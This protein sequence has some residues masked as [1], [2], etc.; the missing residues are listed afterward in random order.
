MAR[1]IAITKKRT[2]QPNTNFLTFCAR[3]ICFTESLASIFESKKARTLWVVG[4][5]GESS[6]YWIFIIVVMVNTNIQSVQYTVFEKVFAYEKLIKFVSNWT[7]DNT[8]SSL[9][10]KVS[11]LNDKVRK[12]SNMPLRQHVLHLTNSGL[13][14]LYQCRQHKQSDTYVNNRHYS[15]SPQLGLKKKTKQDFTHVQGE[16]ILGRKNNNK[17]TKNTTF[18]QGG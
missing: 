3:S 6:V 12:H 13:A 10:H 2:N 4:N 8:Q 9:Y 15:S 5:A 14:V 17:K 18:L 7:L 1:S 16:A 11:F